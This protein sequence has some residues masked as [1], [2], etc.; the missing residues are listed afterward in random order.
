MK[1]AAT[2]LLITFFIVAAG[3]VAFAK[4]FTIKLSHQSPATNEAAEHMASLAMIDYLNK[5]SDGRIE[6]KYFPRRPVGF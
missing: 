6:V 2:V 3:S 5:H 4:T 1:R